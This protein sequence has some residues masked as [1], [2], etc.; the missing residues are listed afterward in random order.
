MRA[1]LILSVIFSTALASQ[2]DD[3]DYGGCTLS[4][5]EETLKQQL[6]KV[7]ERQMKWNNIEWDKSSLEV[8]RIADYADTYMSH[9]KAAKMVPRYSVQFKTTKGSLISVETLYS[10]YG[11]LGGIALWEKAFL[12]TERDAEGFITKK[13]C[14]HNLLMLGANN[15]GF[16][17][18]TLNVKMNFTDYVYEISQD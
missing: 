1:L 8:V 18:L 16:I 17:N 5:Y 15:V 10:F 9:G 12:K 11:A 14:S 2:A 3:L 7:I 13:V 4:N 6:G